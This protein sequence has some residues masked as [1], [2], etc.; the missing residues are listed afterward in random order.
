MVKIDFSFE[1][2]YG[3]FGDSIHLEDDHQL[4]EQDI[5]NMKQERL[6]NWLAA[7]E[8]PSVEAAPSDVAT[9]E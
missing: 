9:Q 7:V 1:T 3:I 8:A 5:E 4:S 2:K 6:N